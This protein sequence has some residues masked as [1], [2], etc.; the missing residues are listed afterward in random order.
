MN[1]VRR[2]LVFWIGLAVS[3]VAWGEM[4]LRLGIMPFNSPLALLRAH[5][6]LREHLQARLGVP[7]ELQT[8]PDFPRYVEDVLAGRFDVIILAPH[9][10]MIAYQDVGYRPLVHYR[11]LLEPLL[12]VRKESDIQRPGQV[13]GKT[14]AAASKLALVTIVGLQRF[15]QDGVL[16]PSM[17]KIDER[18][19]HGAAIAAV[20]LGEVDAALTVE[21]TLRQV[22]EDVR[23][24]IRSISLG[25]ALPHLVTMAHPALGNAR[26]EKLAAAFAEF[27]GTEGGQKFFR[28]TAYGGY[29]VF[30]R[31]D[32]KRL[33]PYAEIARQLLAE[34]NG[35]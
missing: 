32:M 29:D 31:D 7:V 25:T 4:P 2:W 20:A 5:Q 15:R 13:K 6:P 19:T 1:A 34:G 16:Y 28:E 27:P 26:S 10:A 23:A 9:F 8:S 30:D 24:K 35:L 21:T 33:L 12:V 18:V 14:V 17:V 3:S 11:S 22:P